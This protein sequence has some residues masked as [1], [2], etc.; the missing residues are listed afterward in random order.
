MSKKLTR[1]SLK[2]PDALQEQ[3]LHFIQKILKHAKHFTTI[4]YIVL[5]VLAITLSYKYFSVRQLRKDTTLY[6][7][8]TKNI[9]LEDSKELE[10]E[11]KK[12]LPKLKT[13]KIKCYVSYKLADSLFT[14]KK[15]EDA[16]VYY[17]MVAKKGSSILKELAE[18]GLAKS[19]ELTKKTTEAEEVYKE[20]I[21]NKFHLYRAISMFSLAKIYNKQGKKPLAAATLENIIISYK[22]TNYAKM[23]YL[24]KKELN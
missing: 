14:N 2:H 4:V 22:N 3:L 18:F 19:Y 13:K 16:I 1:K 24:Y 7:T 11:F 8:T 6:Y 20:I 9:N 5:G 15:Y 23:A 12:I 10:N 17:K 21:E